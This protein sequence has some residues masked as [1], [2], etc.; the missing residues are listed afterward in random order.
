MGVRDGYFAHRDEEAVVAAIAA[1]EPDILLVAF[2]NPQQEMFIARHFDAL[3]ARTMFGVGALFDF[4]AGKVAR[5]PNWVRRARLEWAFRL[6]QEPGRLVRRY[7]IETARFLLAVL[8]LRL[9]ADER[10]NP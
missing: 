5:A 1:A 2:G 6:A 4:T 8:R 7:T 9:S 3:R 10:R